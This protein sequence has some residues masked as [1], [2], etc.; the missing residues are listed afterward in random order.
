MRCD[1]FNMAET[2]GHSGFRFYRLSSCSRPFRGLNP[3]SLSAILKVVNSFIIRMGFK[4][5]R[6]LQ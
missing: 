6:F 4:Y 3:P 5:L 1:S 2:E